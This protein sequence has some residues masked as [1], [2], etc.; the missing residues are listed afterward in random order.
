MDFELSKEQQL[1]QNT[2]KEY[3]ELN[4]L[5]LQKEHEENH[6]VPL[7]VY[8][9]LGEIGLM[10]LTVSEKYGG[11]GAGYDGYVICLE[12]IAKCNSSVSGGITAHVL[13][14]SMID[15]FGTEEQKQ[16]MLPPGCTGE[17]I[18][19]FAFTEPGTG[20]DPKLITSTAQ[21]VGDEWVLNGTKRFITNA[22]YPGMLGVV[23][24]EVDSGKLT[25]FLIEK[26]QEGYSISERWQK[27]AQNGQGLYDIYLK[28]CRVPDSA[29]VGEVGDGF[30]ILISGIG[31][32]KLGISIQA[33]AC[34][35]LAFEVA[36][37]YA[38]TKTHRGDPITKFQS[39]QL[40]IAEMAEKLEA[41]RLMLHKAAYVGNK[42]SKTDFGL[43]AKTLAM[44]KNFVTENTVDIA[45]LSMEVYSSYGLMADYK[46]ER[47]YRQAIMGPQI[48]GGPRIQ[49]IITANSIIA[50][51]LKK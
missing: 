34:A 31:Y 7:E 5:P 19:S 1:L 20:S 40:I 29:R 12:Q 48:E 10:G 11:S 2:A 8:K 26:F 9:G 41:S 32:G 25:A 42:Y 21:K 44:T 27:I 39:I 3:S 24:K 14:M 28:N 18:H 15:T 35:Q 43:F 50:E 16:R 17:Q 4:L 51:Y 38:T 37:E 6:F 45:R 33:M 49:R 47:L 13:S 22:H 23:V 46:I 36:L 30:K